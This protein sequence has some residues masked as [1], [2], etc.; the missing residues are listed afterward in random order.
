MPLVT[1]LNLRA[2]DRID[3]IEKAVRTALVSLPELAIN[4]HEV[5]LAPI[6]APTGFLGTARIN[7]D[8]W[9]RAERTKE[10]LQEVSTRVANAFKSVVGRGRKVTVVI[11]PYPVAESGWVSS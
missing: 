8:L 2:D 7:V 11:R 1:V 9:T 4:E 6:L 3:E 10:G 5:D